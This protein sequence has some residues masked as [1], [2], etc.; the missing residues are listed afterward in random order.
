M[1]ELE[2]CI[3]LIRNFES[4]RTGPRAVGHRPFD[5]VDQSE[6]ATLLLLHGRD[7]NP[8]RR[9]ASR[10]L[11]SKLT[12][13]GAA[14]A[15]TGGGCAMYSGGPPGAAPAARL[16]RDGSSGGG[17]SARP[18]VLGRGDSS[19]ARR[20]VSTVTVTPVLMHAPDRNHGTYRR[21]PG[22]PRDLPRSD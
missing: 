22:R 9:P 20:H 3:S 10:R 5:V 18:R 2:V 16:D 17:P 6:F 12:G 15:S 19:A 8:R 14:R 7:P 1:P 13:L 4:G 21:P 11:S